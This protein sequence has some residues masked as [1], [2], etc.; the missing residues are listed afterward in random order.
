MR[1]NRL[2]RTLFRGLI[3]VLV[4]LTFPASGLT[5]DS[6]QTLNETV[7]VQ[8]RIDTDSASSQLR[9]SQ[10]ADDTTDLLAQFRLTTQQ[11]D[12]VRV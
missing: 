5:Q 10:L 2:Q 12:R 11:L 8:V 9:I 4:P 7:S 1:A 6:Q 3:V